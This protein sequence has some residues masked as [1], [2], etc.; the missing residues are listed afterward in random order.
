M[1]RA[2]AAR[3]DKAAAKAVREHTVSVE[4][5]SKDLDIEGYMAEM[6]TPLTGLPPSARRQIVLPRGIPRNT[7]RR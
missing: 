4:Q 7:S 5:M 3:I 1:T 6:K 2:I